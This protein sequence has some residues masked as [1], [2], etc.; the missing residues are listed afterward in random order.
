[1]EKILEYVYFVFVILPIL[2]IIHE[3]GHVCAAL[4]FK[5]EVVKI[6][7]GSGKKLFSIH[8][9]DV[10]LFYFWNGVCLFKIKEGLSVRKVIVIFLM[11]AVFNLVAGFI[12][13]WI[14]SHGYFNN[15][16]ESIV[17]KDLISTSF[18]FGLSNLLPIRFRTFHFDG[19]QIMSLIKTGKIKLYDKEETLI[20]NDSTA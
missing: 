13:M 2:T 6:K 4:V 14:R 7:M 20:E 11:G 1:M 19:H 16:F 3:L 5:Q 12:L 10:H 15:I 18:V 9:L 8:K 17:F